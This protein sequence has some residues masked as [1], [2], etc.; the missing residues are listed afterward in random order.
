MARSRGRTIS[1]D[2]W[3][4]V[5]DILDQLSD[6]DLSAEAKR[7]DIRMVMGT[8][9]RWRD[10]ADDLRAAVRSGDRVHFEILICRMMAL[11]GWS[12]AGMK[13]IASLGP[14]ST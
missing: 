12:E 6:D 4:D 9:E 7:R 11:A 8:E 10:L 3:V 14:S 2:V 5:D 13:I 1:V